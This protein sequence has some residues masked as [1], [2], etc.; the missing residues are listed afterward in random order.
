MKLTEGPWH[1]LLAGV[2]GP[3]T[4]RT[5]IGLAVDTGPHGADLLR[6]A[7][8]LA[9]EAPELGYLWV[10]DSASAQGGAL[11]AQTLVAQGV[12]LIIGHFNS[13]SALAAAP[14][15]A[16]A[17]ALL[18]APAATH[19]ALTAAMPRCFRLCAHDQLQAQLFADTL[20]EA[21][22]RPLLIVQRSAHGQS[23]GNAIERL[24]RAV[25]MPPDR[26]DAD[27]HTDTD[28]HTEADAD[29]DA[30][31]QIADLPPGS[32]AVIGRHAFAAAW[33]PLLDARSPRLLSD[34]CCTPRLR[35]AAGA[36]AIGAQVATVAGADAGEAR[37]SAYARTSRAAIEVLAGAVAMAGSH[38]DAVA[39]ALHD[40]SWQTCLGTTA[41]DVQGEPV[42]IGWC[43]QCVAPAFAAAPV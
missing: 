3:A 28:T 15:Y 14:I 37:G 29:A 34:D 23:L 9:D 10:D 5:T 13:G 39:A 24:L 35:D 2:P 40:R 21:G 42:G 18:L 41:F 25:H 7:A 27:T 30:V 17:G 31:A 4:G 36:A 22:G 19:P 32:V 16:P 1:R 26:I 33:L 43:W 20:V 11:A 8:A 12:R 38:P 6:A